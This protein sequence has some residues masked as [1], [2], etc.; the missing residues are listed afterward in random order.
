[1]IV[2]LHQNPVRRGLVSRAEEW[3]WSSARWYAGMSDVLLAMD[4]SLPMMT[5]GRVVC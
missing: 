5:E 3:L 2:Y 1:M 4:R